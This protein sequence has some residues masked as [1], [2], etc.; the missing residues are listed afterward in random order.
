MRVTSISFGANF[1]INS[2]SNRY[3]MNR[4]DLAKEV[5]AA[6]Y[7]RDLGVSVPDYGITISYDTKGEVASYPNNKIGTKHFDKL[8]KNLYIM[9]TNNQNHNDLDIGHVFYSDDGLVEFDCF[10]FSSPFVVNSNRKY[11]LPAFMMPTNQVNY[12]NA[13]LGL[14]VEQ[15]PDKKEKMAFLKDYLK[16]SSVYH[17]EKADYL[18]SN[19]SKIL[20]EDMYDYESVQA[21]V[22]RN[23]DDEMAELLQYRLDFLTKQRRAFTEFDEGNGSFGHEFSAKRRVVSIP[24]YFDAVNAAFEYQKKA[25]ELSD[26]A[27]SSQKRKYYQ[28]ESQF[29]NFFANTYLTWIK[30]MADYNFADDRVCKLEESERSYLNAQYQ[31]ILDADDSKKPDLMKNYL[32][33]YQ[34]KTDS[35]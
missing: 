3:G 24:M 34:R 9:D 15:I 4:N 21:D 30:G 19:R 5:I 31:K 23:P 17:Q 22:L 7:A 13:S 27:D 33:L 12:E 1:S 32:S 16:A 35:F 29:G 2:D 26:K 28:Y 8:F 11:D 6:K 14:Y 25:Q 18:L 10:R 20:T